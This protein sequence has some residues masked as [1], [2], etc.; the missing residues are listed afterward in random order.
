[1]KKINQVCI[2]ALCAFVVTTGVITCGWKCSKVFGGEAGTLHISKSTPT[3]SLMQLISSHTSKI[4]DAIMAGDFNAVTRES[5]AVA[6][7]SEII[8]EM[9]FSSDGKV[10]EWFK[11]AGNNPKTAEE[12]K[13]E[14]E[15][16]L[17]VVIDASRNIAET[18]GKKNIVET[19]K[20]FDEML[21]KACFAC[22][23]VSREKWPD[24]PDWMR[25][26]G[27]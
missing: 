18:A 3:R 19:Y 16:Y 9:F 27:G 7:N 6:E 8:M 12:M 4:L 14:F 24:W 20:S 23:A 17:K 2:A 13:T 25:Q 21:Q 1:M 10:G 26:A 5:N 22:H 11:P 15:K